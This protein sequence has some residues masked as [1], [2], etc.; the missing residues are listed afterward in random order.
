MRTIADDK[1]DGLYKGVD[2]DHCLDDNDGLG[3]HLDVLCLYG[4]QDRSVDLVHHDRV[5]WFGVDVQVHC[6]SWTHIRLQF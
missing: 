1:D 3:D 2:F 6:L 4:R 5:R